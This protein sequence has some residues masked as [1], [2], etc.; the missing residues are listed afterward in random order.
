MLHNLFLTNKQIFEITES[1]RVSS[2]VNDHLA[3]SGTTLKMYYDNFLPHGPVMG[4]V[5][6]QKLDYFEM[7]RTKGM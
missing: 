1:Q 3:M 2:T 7:V 4:Q 5:Q 6:E